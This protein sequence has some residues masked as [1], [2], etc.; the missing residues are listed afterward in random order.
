MAGTIFILLTLSTGIAVGLDTKYRPQTFKDVIGQDVIVS[1]LNTIIKKG[2]YTSAYLFSGPSGTGKTTSARIFAK[3]I[4]CESPIDG[5]PCN[6]C[7]S[8]KLFNNEKHFSYVEMDA[9]SVG[10]KE[11]M[12]K[13]KDDAAYISI[14]SKKIILLDECHDISKQGQDALLKQV[15]QCPEHLIYLFCTTE[16]Q[17]IN[18]TLK[19]RLMIFNFSKVDPVLIFNRLKY[20]CAAE[21]IAFEDQA[22]KNIAERTDGHVRDSIKLLEETAYLGPITKV[23][24]D[25]IFPDYTDQIFNIL[26]NIGSNLSK[27]IDLCNTILLNV[28]TRELYEQILFM[29]EDTTKLLYGYDKFDS[30]RKSYLEKLRDTYGPSI[31]EFFNYM[32]SRDKFV[33]RVGL[34][35]DIIFINYK[36]CSGSFK[37]QATDHKNT[38]VTSITQ[39]SQNEKVIVEKVV[40]EP[41]ITHSQL[42]TMKLEDRQ[43]VLRKQRSKKLGTREEDPL[44]VP[45]K[46][47]LPK[48]RGIGVCSD[49]KELSP[50]EFSKL[51][52]GGRRDESIEK[53]V[54]NFGT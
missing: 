51:L 45:A 20:I 29:L 42:M 37:L 11:D 24:V 6:I 25:K 38:S 46:W 49:H 17:K 21:N 13:L 26:F 31:A 3:A 19:K 18:P 15:E 28:S 50:L 40:A 1:I 48:E 22:L 41:S 54:D 4:L 5:N 33:D 36:L 39:Q 53:K 10:G 8:C 35:G 30:H 43:G 14:G 2:T 52:V 16:P 47:P 9:A 7:S 32:L 44:I 12:K 23:S 27:T 34:H